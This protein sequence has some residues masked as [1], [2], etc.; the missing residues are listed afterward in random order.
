MTFFIEH[1]IP[2]GLEHFTVTSLLVF[3]FIGKHWQ[4]TTAL[5]PTFL[6]SIREECRR[7]THV[8][9]VLFHRL[10]GHSILNVKITM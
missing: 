1:H 10:K 7:N 8:L 3:E 4:Y 2:E 9:P 5:F 6:P